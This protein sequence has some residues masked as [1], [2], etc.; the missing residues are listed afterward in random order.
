MIVIK[1]FF[2][3]Y[4]TILFLFVLFLFALLLRISFLY[5]NLFFGP[6]QGIDFFAIKD[7]VIHHKL[8]LIGAKTDVSGIFHGPIYYYISALPFLLSAGDPYFILLFLIACNCLSVFFL[9]FLG[10]EL[11]SKRFGV[12][13]AVLFAFSFHAIVYS[14]WLSTHPLAIPLSSLSMLYIVRFVK[15]NNKDLL[16]ASI[17][18][19]FL[20]QSEFLNILFFTL[21]TIF[22]GFIFF[23][24]FRKQ[25]F[26]YL[27][28]CILIT[29]A[30]AI[31]PFLLF[32]LRHSFLISK[33]ILLLAK[34]S[35]GYHITYLNSLTGSLSSLLTLV[36][37]TVSPSYDLI[38]FVLIFAALGTLS[39][40]PKRKNKL[41]WVVVI[42]IITPPLVLITLRHQVLNQFFVS[43]IPAVILLI[44]FFINVAWD[45]FL[46][47]GMIILL[48]LV[49][50][51]AT[52]YVNYIP[53]NENIF[54]QS[55]QLQLKYS[56]EIA[57][58][59]R[60]YQEANHKPFSIQAYTIPYWSQQGWEYLFQYYGLR[61]YG[62]LPL[63]EKART[64]F[65]IIQDD[66]SYKSFQD[67]W[68]KNT[69]SK[70][71]VP[72]KSFRYGVL[73]VEELHVTKL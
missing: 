8:T 27:L 55:T 61:K 3:R 36:S 48:L 56:D 59:N 60:I 51:N 30:I 49:G 2:H 40:F 50:C 72:V 21:I 24:Q 44:A 23:K 63:V 67:D 64:L 39:I 62:Y 25:N 45:T 71:G 1:N 17:A 34:G 7:I 19:G 33:N 69:V 9:F 22:I 29:F 66:P 4:F 12:I 38:A 15:G 65:V 16:F 43:L 70:W 68:L 73:N 46:A 11:I 6:E 20:M 57:V 52:A 10:K 41:L 47:G 42:W 53:S 35:T 13:A 28:L 37:L 18:L 14:R 5:K 32:D 31:G 26:L 54:F 58:I